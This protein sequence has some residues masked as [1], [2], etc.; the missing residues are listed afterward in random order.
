[1]KWACVFCRPLSRIEETD[2]WFPMGSER[3]HTRVHHPADGGPQWYH[4]H[5]LWCFYYFMFFSAAYFRDRF[6]CNCTFCLFLPGNSGFIEA[7]HTSGMVS[8]LLSL[9]A[10]SEGYVRASAVT[11]VGEAVTSSLHHTVLVSN[12]NLLVRELLNSIKSSFSN[13]IFRMILHFSFASDE[14]AC[15]WSV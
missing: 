11:V 15:F 8:I 4:K 13:M 6:H 14:I 1:M 2:V 3:L 12:S 9:L 5:K 7:L 10:D